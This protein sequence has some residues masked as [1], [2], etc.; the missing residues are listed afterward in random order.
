MELDGHLLYIDVTQ[1]CGIGCDFCMYDALHDASSSDLRL[2]PKGREN[3]SKLINNKSVKRVSISGEGEP[4][5][6]IATIL[7]IIDLSEG[8]VPF[9]LI[10]SG[11]WRHDKLV[12]LYR[13]LNAKAGKK[14]DTYNVRLST[15]SYHT[16]RLKNMPQ[17]RTM[18]FFVDEDPENLTLSFRSIC[19]D[20]E[21]TRQFL[22]EQAREFGLE[23][24]AVEKTELDDVLNLER[25]SLGINY[26]NLVNPEQCSREDYTTLEEYVKAME[27]KSGKP[28]TLGSINPSPEPNGLDI[29][30]KPNGSVL[31]YGLEVRSVG[32][33]HKDD[34][35]IEDLRRIVEEDPLFRVFYSVPL[36]DLIAIISEDADAKEI[37]KRANNPYW[38]VKFLHEQNKLDVRKLVR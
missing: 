1:N 16:P 35:S 28:F 20:R 33:V 29:T 21:Y 27:R 23:A 15:D 30:I 37:I 18:R 11:F 5:N 19:C 17:G 9:E 25:F 14:N 36:L 2:T 4:L 7:E 8:G 31:L 34:I 26:K 32:N 6:N 22:F 13:R 3:V 24:E 10:T 38:V 12:E